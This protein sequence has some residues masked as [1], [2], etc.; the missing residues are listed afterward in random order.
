MAF[1]VRRGRGAQQT[2]AVAQTG[3]SSLHTFGHDSHTVRVDG[4]EVD[5][6]E[7]ADEVGLGC[8]LQGTDCVRSQSQAGATRRKRLGDLADES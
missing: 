3:V 6:F 8:L 5:I 1:A 7:K 2:N 4:A